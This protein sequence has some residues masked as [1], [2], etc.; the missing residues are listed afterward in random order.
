MKD[1]RH[2]AKKSFGQNFL[3]NKVIARKI[4]SALGIAP[5]DSVLEIGPGKGVLTE[6]ILKQ[7]A[8]AKIHFTA[9]EKD[10]LL[11]EGLRGRCE[12]PWYEIV[13]DDILRYDIKKALHGK[14]TLKVIG[15]IPY[16]IT[17]DI[18]F[19][20]LKNKTC[21]DTV[22]L[23]A[24]REFVDRLVAVPGTKEYG[25]I[26]VMLSRY[27]DVKAL[28]VI[29]PESFLPMPRVDSTVFS[30]SF[31]DVGIKADDDIFANVVR[32]AFISRRKTLVNTLK[33][34][35]KTLNVSTDVVH[36]FLERLD[37]PVTVRGE[38]LSVSQFE[39]LAYDI[40]QARTKN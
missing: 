36:A 34:Y 15:N 4:V 18:I 39:T 37:M 1:I 20:I 14:K 11:I 12:E 13:S 26:T 38:V 23:T 19:N 21:V 22:V 24:Q 27:A 2:R 31:H 7:Y 10:R 29:K 8:H 30:L 28:F 32:S 33:G 9:V 17:T 5:G 40:Q 6:I 16:N 25:R 35:L 3:T